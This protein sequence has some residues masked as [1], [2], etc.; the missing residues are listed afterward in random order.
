MGVLYCVFAGDNREITFFLRIFKRGDGDRG[1]GVWSLEVE[2]E[3]TGEGGGHLRD[4]C[5][6]LEGGPVG[7]K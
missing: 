5:G 7:R 1:K 3:R 4:K 6:H 2:D